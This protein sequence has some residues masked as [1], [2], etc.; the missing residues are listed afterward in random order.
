[1]TQARMVLA[2]GILLLLFLPRF[3]NIPLA[4]GVNLDLP[5]LFAVALLAGFWAVQAVRGRVAI[6]VDRLSIVY[7]LFLLT[8]FVSALRSPSPAYSVVVFFGEICLV[9]AFFYYGR[10]AQVHLPSNRTFARVLTALVVYATSYLII[11]KFTGFNPFR[12]IGIALGG[13]QTVLKESM[14]G[15]NKF[16]GHVP[17]GFWGT[18]LDAGQILFSLLFLVLLVGFHRHRTLYFS[19][20]MLLLATIVVV[21]SRAVYLFVVLFLLLLTVNPTV[22][23]AI[24][25]DAYLRRLSLATRPFLV[26]TV[27]AVL[28]LLIP[29][30]FVLPRSIED[31]FDI[32]FS[33][34]LA[35][36]LYGLVVA[37]QIVTSNPYGYGYGVVTNLPLRSVSVI[38]DQFIDRSFDF[39][40]MATIAIESGVMALAF[41][42]TVL[43]MVLRRAWVA[44]RHDPTAAHFLY[45]AY[46]ATFPLL[47]ATTSAIYPL[48]I[49]FF[50]VGNFLTHLE[51]YGAVDTVVAKQ[52]VPA[53]VARRT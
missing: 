11:E 13:N 37:F 26:M 19:L 9:Y 4:F 53:L 24:I 22:S 7:L 43:T 47:N 51:S 36:R 23:R 25:R 41:Y 10:N 16:L 29:A 52:R 5:K 2:I 12:S 31:I 38:W 50:I 1:M 49:F 48:G 42:L 39:S 35:R 32:S 40:M 17:S 44:Y 34:T 15:L 33:S 27:T 20:A 8:L 46:F 18:W 3:V 28:F 30:I 14:V 21:Q 6:R 45:L